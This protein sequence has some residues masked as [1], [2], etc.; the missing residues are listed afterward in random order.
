LTHY[1]ANSGRWKLFESES[2]EQGFTVRGG[3]QWFGNV[4][5]AA[6][7]ENGT[8]QVRTSY[9]RVLRLVIHSIAEISVVL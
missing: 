1:N 6:T 2:Q 7:E 4:L 8:Y 5:I 9:L 3:M